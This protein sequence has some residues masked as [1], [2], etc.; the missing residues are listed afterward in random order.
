MS[1]RKAKK[2][3][4][5]PPA[6]T[7]E[8]TENESLCLKAY[9]TG[10]EQG[11][12]WGRAIISR[13]T[14]LSD[15][16][17]NRG[18]SGLRRKGVIPPR[19]PRS[20]RFYDGDSG[21]IKD[22]PESVS[23][24]KDTK[25][26]IP[27]TI[28]P[29]DV[30]YVVEDG[31]AQITRLKAEIADLKKNQEWLTHSTAQEHRGGTFTLNLSD[32]HIFD[33]GF[34]LNVM[35]NLESKTIEVLDRFKPRKFI[36]VLNGDVIPGTG[37]Y[38]NQQLENVLPRTDQQVGA[39]AYRFLEFDRM[40][41]ENFDGPREWIVIEGNHDRSHGE[42]IIMKFVMAIRQFDVPARFAGTECVV[43]VADEGT[44]NILFEHGYGNSSFGP[45]SNKQI[46]ETYRKIIGYY[47]RGWDGE[48]R[49][50]RVAGGHTHWLN[51]GTERAE[52]LEFD[53]TGGLHRNDRANIGKN[54]RPAGW[55]V[56]I[57]PP[58]S[59]DIIS[60]IGLKPSTSIFRVDI[61]DPELENK[62]RAEA[63]RCLMAF[64]DE[65]RK[66]GIISNEAEL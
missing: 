62:N 24:D 3:T 54:T 27:K 53:T 21:T 39:G 26:I 34:M 48:K 17:V 7:I 51:V 14:G 2:T 8:L 28:S 4:K 64:A 58:G 20:G 65:A 31:A 43:N 66:R 60:P 5:P 36:G 47:A 35:A 12:D 37:I 16:Q 56:Y 22:G 11:D 23:D 45:T 13:K 19:A 55:I 10:Q 6:K 25:T 61:E 33:R 63:A 15:G 44:Y 1:G 41:A 38:R 57:S 40:I 29:S 46:M 49:I 42:P 52:G 32:L 9:R 59:S 50:R 30:G 18:M